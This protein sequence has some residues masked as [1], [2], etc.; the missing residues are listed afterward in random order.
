MSTV[1]QRQKFNH[2]STA[3][4]L[5]KTTCV[6]SLGRQA[7]VVRKASEKKPNVI[8]LLAT[9][10]NY[11]SKQSQKTEKGEGDGADSG[12]LSLEDVIIPDCLYCRKPISPPCWFC[13]DCMGSKLPS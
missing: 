11:L 2:S 7:Q 12:D 5:L 8:E 4:I 9:S 1:V 13:V 10:E 3:H 6:I